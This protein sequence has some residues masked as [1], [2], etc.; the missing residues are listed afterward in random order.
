MAPDAT[1]AGGIDG[2]HPSTVVQLSSITVAFGGL[3]A[4]GGVDLDVARGQ[5]LAIL[6]PN[7]AGK[8]TLF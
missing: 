1:A 7:G 5:R 8:T 4:L 3:L 6:G 2:G